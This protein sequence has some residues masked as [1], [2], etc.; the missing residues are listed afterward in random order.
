MHKQWIVGVSGGPDS[1]ALLDKLSQQG[2]D[3]VAAHVNYGKRET[4]QRDEDI[5]KAYCEKHQ[6]TF[7]CLNYIDD[8]Q[9]HNFQH[10][11]REFRYAFFRNLVNKYQAEG[12]AVAHHFNDDLETYL[13]QKKRNMESEHIGLAEYTQIMGITVWRPLLDMTKAMILKYCEEQQI[14]FGIDESNLSLDYTRNQIRHEI[15]KLDKASYESLVKEMVAAKQCGEKRSKIVRSIALQL[16]SKVKVD[17]YALIQDGIRTRVLRLWMSQHG[18]DTHTM[19]GRFLKELDELILQEKAFLQFGD[20]RL[21]S[22]YGELSLAKNAAFEYHYNEI[23]YESTNHFILSKTGQTI[24][25]V[26]LSE[27]D[28]PIVIRNAREGDAIKMRF[29]TKSLNR[30]FIDRKIPRHEREL[31]PVIVNS[32][33]QIVFVVGMGCDA[34]HYSNNPNLFMLEL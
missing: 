32:S 22:S 33:Q 10:Q 29:G 21:S 3:C 11:A 14:H 27:S 26:T 7:E 12:V 16:G 19:S 30:F 1:M 13:F 28:F 18:V 20:M 34:H 17:M 5:V 23:R 15:S 6:I 2:I 25:G 9:N 31:C 24:Q 8:G 4:S